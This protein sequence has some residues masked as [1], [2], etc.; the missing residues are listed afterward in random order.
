MRLQLIL[1]DLLMPICDGFKASLKIIDILR[2]EYTMKINPGG[3]PEVNKTIEAMP[4]E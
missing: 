2:K 3:D 4:L 1:M